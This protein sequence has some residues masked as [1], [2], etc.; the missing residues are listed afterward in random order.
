MRPP[1][2]AFLLSKRG[3]EVPRPPP[4]LL[5]AMPNHGCYVLW[6][7]QTPDAATN[8]LQNECEGISQVLGVS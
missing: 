5:I 1:I 7:L 3:A 8:A 2:P 4:F 6:V